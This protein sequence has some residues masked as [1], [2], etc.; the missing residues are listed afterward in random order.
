MRGFLWTVA[1]ILALA[2]AGTVVA[3]VTFVDDGASGSTAV[4]YRRPA[5]GFCYY[6]F[7]IVKANSTTA[8]QYASQSVPNDAAFLDT[9][10]VGKDF[11]RD[12]SSNDTWRSRT[13]LENV[14]VVWLDINY[15][16]LG[17]DTLWVRYLDAE[18]NPIGTA[19]RIAPPGGGG[20]T[21]QVIPSIPAWGERVVLFAGRATAATEEW[22]VTSYHERWR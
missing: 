10:Q 21:L 19:R 16:G 2:L 14:P 9:L 6:L 8:D 7:G 11:V 12:G 20:A 22:Q 4:T 15:Y 1:A 17:G 5:S 18:D 3:D 13:N